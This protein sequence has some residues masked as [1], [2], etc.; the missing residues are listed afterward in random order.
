MAPEPRSQQCAWQMQ[1]APWQ[2]SPEERTPRGAC[3]AAT[4]LA[5]SGFMPSHGKSLDRHASRLAD[6]SGSG[7]WELGSTGTWTGPFIASCGRFSRAGRPGQ[8]SLCRQGKGGS[9]GRGPGGKPGKLLT[10]GSASRRAASWESVRKTIERDR[11][12]G[13]EAE[14]ALCSRCTKE[15]GDPRL[16]VTP[17]EAC[18]G[19]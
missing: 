16:L 14:T 2:T 17:E 19:K 1:V 3:L 18:L 9:W 12:A 4:V 11:K 15:G 8:D 6:E 10:Q 7:I 13:A 5:W